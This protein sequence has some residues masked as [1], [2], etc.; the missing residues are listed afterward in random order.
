MRR[1]AYITAH[2]EDESGSRE[3]VFDEE[4]LYEQLTNVQKI[5]FV[6]GKIGGGS[7]SEGPTYWGGENSLFVQ[8]AKKYFDA[9]RAYFTDQDY[10]Y[11]GSADERRIAGYKYAM[12]NHEKIT[13]GFYSNELYF[14]VITHSMG[15]A[16]GEGIIDYLKKQGYAVDQTLHLS[17]FQAADIKANKNAVDY[18][19]TYVVDFQLSNDPVINNPIRSSPG[20]IE[21]A[22]KKIRIEANV[23]LK[24]IHRS[25]IDY[26]TQFWSLL[27]ECMNI[28]KPFMIYLGR[29]WPE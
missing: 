15:A 6:N 10:E 7:P 19:G 25:P 13:E 12:D 27:E 8:G 5:L 28:D 22:D 16:Y 14:K 2:W 11:L 1:I 3:R 17:P 23:G 9:S 4:L 18:V 20:S 26:P 21:N 29:K 24:Y